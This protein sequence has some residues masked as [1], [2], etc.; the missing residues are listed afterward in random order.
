[1]L[2]RITEALTRRRLGGAVLLLAGIAVAA[3]VLWPD[4]GDDD[5]PVRAKVAPVR[6]VSVP[7]L[8]L[9]FGHPTSWKR[10]VRGRVIELRS[11]DRSVVMIFSSPVAGEEPRAAKAA[12]EKALR[13][14]FAPAKIV[15]DGP[16]K[17][18]PRTVA[19]FELTGRDKTGPVRVLVLVGTTPQRTYVVTLLTG[20]DPTVARIREARQILNTVRFSKPVKG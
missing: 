15:R 18:G 2:D 11:P 4:D 1:M 10:T 12:A 17:L 14:Q 5:E 16:G 7:P 9:A 8:G 19:T 20:G 13:K 3:I 6:L